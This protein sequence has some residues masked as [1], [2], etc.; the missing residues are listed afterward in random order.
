MKSFVK[1]SKYQTP[2]GRCLIKSNTYQHSLE[3]INQ[4][5]AAARADFPGLK[6]AEISIK[7]YDDERWGKQMGIEFDAKRHLAYQEITK[8]PYTY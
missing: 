4:L 3:F 1:I 6:D 2:K 5:V 8:L 7:L